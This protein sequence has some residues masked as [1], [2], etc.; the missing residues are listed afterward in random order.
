MADRTRNDVLLN[1]GLVV[2]AL[3]VGV[4]VWGG[5]TRVMG[6][7]A[8]DTD[9][10]R[11]RIQVEVRNAAGVDGLAA[12]TTDHLRRHGFDVV[13]IGNAE[14][15]ERTTVVV[16]SGTALDARNVAQALGLG[17]DRVVTGGPTTDYALDV[18]VYVGT[19]FEAL[20]PFASD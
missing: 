6:P 17:P 18:T 20:A 1:A 15:R 11:A 8:L 5:V 10:E 16:R 4:L 3:V 7:R 2:G 12:T 19:D 13:D 9:P 14:R